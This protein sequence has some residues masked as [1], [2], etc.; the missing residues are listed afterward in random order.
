MVRWAMAAIC[1]LSTSYARFDSCSIY[2]IHIWLAHSCSSFSRSQ[3]FLNHIQRVLLC[4]L[5]FCPSYSEGHL[6]EVRDW[7]K[8][9][10]A[11]KKLR[12]IWETGNWSSGH[13]GGSGR[14]SA[15]TAKRSACSLPGT[16]E[17]PRTC[18]CTVVKR[19]HLATSIRAY[20]RLM[21]TAPWRLHR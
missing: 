20:K 12:L 14:S 6:G 17:W 16:P 9:P 3:T 10:S 18:T 13:P 11:Q 19:A 8:F 1:G 4:L 15:A 7:N 21:Q 2:L 5:K